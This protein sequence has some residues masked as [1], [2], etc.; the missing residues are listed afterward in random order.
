MKNCGGEKRSGESEGGQKFLP[1][2]QPPSFLPARA[3][4]FL[5]LPREAR[6]SEF[7]IR[8]FVKKSSDFNQKAVGVRFELTMRFPAY[9]LSKQALSTTQPSH[10]F[11]R[12]KNSR[13][14][15]PPVEFRKDLYGGRYAT[16]L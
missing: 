11:I 7:A 16:P 1:P 5:F 12:G 15:L 6:Q 3:E 10:H 8:I 2:P 13:T 9:L 4:K 14:S